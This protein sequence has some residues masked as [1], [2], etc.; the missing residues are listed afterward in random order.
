[1]GADFPMIPRESALFS[2]GCK[3]SSLRVVPCSVTGKASAP[4]VP[5]FVPCLWLQNGVRENIAWLKA[6]DF[7]A[8]FMR[9][10]SETSMKFGRNSTTEKSETQA[11]LGLSLTELAAY[12]P[13]A[14]MSIRPLFGL[15]QEPQRSQIY[16]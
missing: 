9:F 13:E 8:T 5:W 14:S 1:M 16:S 3:L 11:A 12:P 10:F 7:Y 2:R 4:Q 15:P 6:I